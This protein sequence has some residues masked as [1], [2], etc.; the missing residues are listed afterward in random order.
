[1]SKSA[2]PARL[3]RLRGEIAESGLQGMII[4]PGPNSRY[5]TGVESMLLERPFM[6]FVPASGDVRLVAP[7]LESGPYRSCTIPLTIHSWT[8]SEGS[9]VAI[10]ATVRGLA[11]GRWGVEGRLPFR[12]LAHL[13][14]F[15]DVEF[16]D[17]EPTLQQLREVKDQAEVKLLKVSVAKLGKSFREIPNLLEEGITEIELGKRIADLIYSNGAVPESQLIVQSGARTANPHGFASKRKIGRKEPII[18]DLV[19]S[20]EGY[21]ADITR[22]FCMGTSAELEKVY[23]GVLEANSLACAAVGGGARAGAVDAAAREHLRKVG[24]GKYFTHRTGHGLGLEIHEPP[25]IVERGKEQLDDGMFFTIEPGAYLPG[26]L[27]VRIEDDVTLVKG[28]GAVLS[29]VPKEYGWW[30]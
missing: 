26:R 18:L 20:H 27:G 1:M 14:R 22:T 19:S 6:L 15:F 5:L 9:A 3:E 17:G 2:N 13:R 24:L 8:D 23:A 7:E 4:S 16:E 28:R 30:N 21:Y 10:K 29:D 12:F 11:K 25:Y